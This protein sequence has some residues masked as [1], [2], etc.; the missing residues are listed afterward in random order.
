MPAAIACARAGAF[1]RAVR[2]EE[3]T[4]WLAHVVM[5]LPAWDAAHEEVRAHVRLAAG[6]RDAA[7]QLFGVAAAAFE[8]AGQPLDRDRC[9]ELARSC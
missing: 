5:R 9:R 6:D 1:E 3:A 2:Y 8:S 7:Q 4:E